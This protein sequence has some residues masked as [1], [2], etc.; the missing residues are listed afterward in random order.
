MG[1][2]TSPEANILKKRALLEKHKSYGGFDFCNLQSM[3]QALLFKQA[4][5]MEIKHDLMVS[6]I[7]RAEYSSN[8]FGKSLKGEIPK[9]S[10]WGSRTIMSSVTNMKESV[11]KIIEN[12]ET[13]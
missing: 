4:W 10:T 3:N 12:G 9:V 2:K 8:W 6:K 1:L 11:G 5:R 13:T 7:F